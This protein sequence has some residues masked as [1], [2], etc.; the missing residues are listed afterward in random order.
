VLGTVAA[1]D[2]SHIEVT[3]PKGSTV[4][5]QVTQ[6]TRYRSKQ[7]SGANGLPKVGDRVVIEVIKDGDLLTATEVQFASPKSPA[8]SGSR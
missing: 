4:T 6:N 7:A 5:V 3:T 1:L 8:T 2:K